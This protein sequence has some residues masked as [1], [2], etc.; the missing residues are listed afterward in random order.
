M[1]H[2]K[3]PL[4]KFYVAFLYDLSDCRSRLIYSF[5]IRF[6]IVPFSVVISTK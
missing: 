4:I 2:K 5:K 1:I 3:M 6:V